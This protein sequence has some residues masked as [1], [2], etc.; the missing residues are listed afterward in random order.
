MIK[1]M[2]IFRDKLQD[3]LIYQI[4]KKDGVTKNNSVYC[5]LEK[6]FQIVFI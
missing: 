1:L 5:G 4:R 6:Y 2:Y 3:F